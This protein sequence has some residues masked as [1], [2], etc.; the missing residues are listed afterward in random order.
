M[1]KNGINHLLGNKWDF[2]YIII[3][4]ARERNIVCFLIYFYKNSKIACSIDGLFSIIGD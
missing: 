3:L 4:Y 2:M 1:F